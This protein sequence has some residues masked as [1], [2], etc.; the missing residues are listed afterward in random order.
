MHRKAKR[1]TYDREA[2]YGIL[3][4]ALIAAVSVVV[5]G[6]PQ[7]QP[8]IHVRDGDSIILHGLAGNRLLGLIASGAELCLNVTLIDALALARLIED[9]SMLY[10]SATIYGRGEEIADLDEK[11]EIMSRVF[12]SFVRSARM[13]S[14]PPLDRNYLGGTMVLRVTI[15]EAVGKV[16]REVETSDGPEGIWSGIVPVT[17]AFGAPRPDARTEADGLGVPHEIAAY[18][19]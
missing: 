2:I 4:E 12:A 13:A 8:M 6:H 9:H 14:L 3:D 17:T 19:R 10:R 16:N 7:V 1:A 15:E 11:L 18:G 5:D